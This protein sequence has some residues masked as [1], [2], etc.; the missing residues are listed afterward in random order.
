MSNIDKKGI[1]NALKSKVYYAEL[2][3]KLDVSI[4]DNT[5]Y[6]TIDA[7]GV[8][9][10]MQNDASAFEGWIFCIKS[11]ISAID[12]TIID[13]EKPAFSSEE[14]IYKSQKKHYNRFWVRVIWFIENYSWAAVAN[15]KEEEIC[16]FNRSLKQLTLNYPLQKSKDKS[17]K[18]DT[19]Q[20][21]KY[22]AMLETAI[23]QYLSKTGFS[24]HQLPMGLFDR[25]VSLNT[26]ITPGGASQAD[27]WKIENG[28]F[29][30]YELKD[31]INTDNTHV[32]II[33]ELMFYANVLYRLLITQDIH[34]PSD[35]EALRNSKRDK[36]TRGIEHILDAIYHHSITN[37]KAV[38]L[39]DRL[40]PLIEYAKDILL[41]EMSQ[42]RADITYE[43]S[44]VLQLMPADMIP[45]PSY[46]ETQGAQQ[47]RVLHSLPEFKGVN[48]GG[49]WKAGLQY[50]Q[51]PYI[52]EDGREDLN[53][54][55]PIRK[56]ALAYFLHNNIE[57]W[58]NNGH[59]NKPTGH[60]LSSQISCINHLFPFMKHDESVYL[61]S[62]L[63]SIQHKYTFERILPNPLDNEMFNG[64]IC[65]EFVWKNRSLLGENAETRGARCTSI[66]AVIYAETTD[67]KR[68]LIP[69][70]WKYV[71]TYKHRRAP[72]KSIDRYPSR[73]NSNSNIPEWKEEYEYDPLYELARQ[74]LLVENIIF[75]KDSSLPVD[76]YIHIIVIPEGNIELRLEVD[77]YARSLKNPSKFVIIAPKQMM[78]PIRRSHRDLYEYLDTRYW[79]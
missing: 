52:I 70:E 21:M 65:F 31:C 50:I 41:A 63:N 19:D 30:V 36:A 5:L 24:N 22:E 72:Q 23:Y 1:L 51:L 15:N 73:I 13:W 48:G 34:Y 43:H 59:K 7:E 42:C 60:M 4:I 27:L 69:I 67:H 33:T 2:P 38:L 29:T 8:L 18:S 64:N 39:T 11:L 28:D 17:R 20:K 54:F 79:S 75:N 55:S 61:L 49:K 26:A 47:V 77:Q 9:Q 6:I 66:D 58:R 44:T 3:S 35:T 78:N 62:I 53:L 76:D 56:D 14:K 37:I 57:W 16:D 12:K 45:T 74:T 68:I 25:T 71:E 40:H 46:K 32:G 10:N